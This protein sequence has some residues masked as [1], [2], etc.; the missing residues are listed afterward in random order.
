MELDEREFYIE[1]LSPTHYTA[2]KIKETLFEGQSDYQTIRVL[3]TYDFGKLLVLDDTI[4]TAELDE[5]IY[6]EVLVHPPLLV[7]D[8]SSSVLVIGGGDGGMI[9]ELSKHE[10]LERIDMVELDDLVVD[11]S[12]KHLKSICGDAFDDERV[13]LV[14]GDGREHVESTD[15]TYD[16]V[17]LDLTDPI[18]PSRAL[19]T[20]EFYR[21]LASLLRPDG[22]V[23][24]HGGGWLKYPKVT[25]TVVRTL[26]EVFEQV[27]AFPCYIP[28]YGMELAFVYASPTLDLT[29]VSPERFAARHRSFTEG[30]SLQYVT[31]GFLS[32][33]RYRPKPFD[34]CLSSPRQVSTDQAPLDFDELYHWG[35]TATRERSTTE[36]NG[37]V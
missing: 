29:T 17:I 6:H 21:M 25:S 18:G 28:S 13:N 8:S 32:L 9:E 16:V 37:G 7:R 22:V 19:Y 5:H 20:V 14:I 34:E 12:K 24:T 23:A 27:V 11:V 31:E 10:E 1:D 30:H 15:A 36:S 2:V 35:R 26:G 33:I 3:D 4:Q